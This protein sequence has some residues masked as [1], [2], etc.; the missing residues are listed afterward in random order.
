MKIL[1]IVIKFIFWLLIIPWGMM[2]TITLYQLYAVFWGGV[3]EGE[4]IY[5]DVF[6]PSKT[7]AI[8]FFAGALSI[9][10]IILGLEH[11]GTKTTDKIVK[12]RQ[13]PND[14]QVQ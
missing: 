3:G 6:A 14:C 8:I 2:L 5:L 4:C 13:K 7:V 11:Y 10:V 12:K 1:K 9:F